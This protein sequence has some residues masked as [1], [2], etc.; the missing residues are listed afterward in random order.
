M[1]L[2]VYQ[3]KINALFK[4]DFNIPIIYFTQLIGIALGLPLRDLGL[5][6]LAVKLTKPMKQIFE[7]ACNG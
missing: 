6:R 4:T 1:N 5:G 3:G 7:G 2:D